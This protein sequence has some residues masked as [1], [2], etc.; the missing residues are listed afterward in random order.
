MTAVRIVL[1]FL[2]IFL[3]AIVP[4]FGQGGLYGTIVDGET[5][6]PLIGANI[7]AGDRG[8]VTDFDGQYNLRLDPGEYE[9]V[10]S[11][12]GYAPVTHQ[13]TI[14]RQPQLLNVR[15]GGSQILREITVTADIARERETPVA[16]SNIPTIQLQEELASQDLPMI[17][18]STPGAY[19]TQSGGGDGDAR[20]TIRGFNQRN[21]AVMLDGIPV[22]D[23]ENGWVYWSNWFGLDLVT[24]TMQVQR[25]LGAS[26]LAIPSVGGTINIL[27]RGI[28]SDFGVRFNQEIGS[29]N[30]LRTTL[31]ITSGRLNN[32]WAISAAGSYKQGD[33]YVDGNFTQG[34]FY[35]LR[36]DKQMGRHMI[37]MSG[38]GA[39]QS[40]GQRSFTTA[41]QTTDTTFARQ[42]GMET[43]D[44]YDPDNTL[45][46][47]QGRRFNQHVGYRDGEVFNT[48]KNFYHKPQ[49]S[50]RHS[51]EIS[52]QSFLSNIAYLSLGNGGGT[53]LSS[54]SSN[55]GYRIPPRMYYDIDSMITYNQSTSIF[56]PE[57]ESEHI[58]TANINNHF[59]V[60]M[61]S[62]FQHDFNEHF[63]FSG[64]LDLRYYE[65]DHYRIVYDLLGGEFT[66]A[67]GSNRGNTRV[68]EETHR[69]Y[70][71]D[72]MT[73]DNTG[74]VRWGGIFGMGEYKKNG[75]TAF[76]NMTTA[77]T[78]Y[79]LTDYMK[80]KIVNLPDT[81]FLVR[82]GDSIPYQGS[83]YTLNSPEAVD[84]S[85]GWVNIPSFTAKAGVS[86]NLDQRNQVYANAGYISK[87]Q[88]FNN[89]INSRFG[90]VPVVFQ[91]YENEL[92]K[93]VE[94]GYSYQSRIF[95]ANVNAYLTVWD[96]KPLER[97]P[98]TLIDPSDPDS[99]RIPINIP[100]VAATH[101][102]IEIDFAYR[103]HRMIKIE[104]LA[105]IGDWMW[106]S[107]DTAIIYL[108][109][110]VVDQYEFDATGV[111]VGDAAQL[112]FG[113][114][115]R[116][117]PVKGLYFQVRGTYFGKN[118]SH[119]DPETLQGENGGRQSWQMPDY[120]LF[121]F[122][123][124]Y[125]RRFNR[126]T[127]GLRFN[128]LNVLDTVYI[129]DAEN[130]GNMATPGITTQSFDARS[131]A[132]HFGPG[133]R[134]TTSF[135]VN[136]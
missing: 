116:I 10:F 134:W 135:F 97:T 83:Y 130:N 14:T 111:Y 32:G 26:K 61:L 46:L 4:V 24:R 122:H 126:I 106:T 31:G 104:G 109:G 45:G 85:T 3:W 64:G 25:G 12:V 117:E 34:W 80:P 84:Q 88:R 99:E 120:M 20:I 52:R 63:T 123:A 78:G 6:E 71:G 68:N 43:A 128:V 7:V 77:H 74:F 86:Y 132:V 5:D 96:N 101:K 69:L 110:G 22:N 33:G 28:E 49:F 35:Y 90:D 73:Y 87:A 9:V 15:M 54:R 40:H 100:G 36:I 21:V 23:M 125:S 136:F 91:N 65:G 76:L 108:P 58:I 112:Q 11:Y 55:S 89:V 92:I 8:T 127:A 113:G 39:P 16:F 129:S 27:T 53:A 59:W 118:Y 102:G 2:Y 30:F 93:A 119:F 38:F 50:I 57:P 37:S 114:L 13:V 29:D 42:L 124:G 107:S 72:R 103:P 95:S 98:S 75:W 19:A 133:R 41:I 105:S 18:N 44:I 1:I 79:S 94:L 67:R 81:S 115:V 62:T 47:H 66:R 70:E 48:R 17:L 60:G 56:R 131:A 82:Y 121:N 51:W